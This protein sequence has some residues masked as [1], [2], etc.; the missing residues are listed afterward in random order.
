MTKSNTSYLKELREKKGLTY[1]AMAKKLGMSKA[2]YWQLEH[3]NR[4]LSYDTAKE[5]AKIFDLKPD[6]IFFKDN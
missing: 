2:F 5:I 3:N 6:D 4:R 1:E